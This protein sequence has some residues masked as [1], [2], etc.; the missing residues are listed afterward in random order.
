MKWHLLW[1]MSGSATL[2][3]ALWMLLAD[4]S[5]GRS[6][7]IPLL[8]LLGFAALVYFGIRA[9]SCKPGS[10][11]RTAFVVTL[12][13][14]AAIPLFSI[15]WQKSGYKQQMEAKEL[16]EQQREHAEQQRKYAEA[17]SKA[18]SDS[19]FIA[20]SEDGPGETGELERA[21]A[22]L[23]QNRLCIENFSPT[24][25]DALNR[26][27]KDPA[28]LILQTVM[29]QCSDSFTAWNLL[30]DY[31]TDDSLDVLHWLLEQGFSP[32]QTIYIV[33][34]FE[35]FSPNSRIVSRHFD[36][37]DDYSLMMSPL[38][39]LA[40]ARGDNQALN[41][42]LT[43]GA[44]ITTR[45]RSDCSALHIGARAGNIEAMRLALN[46]G[47]AP[48][49][50]ATPNSWNATPL[51]WAAMSA[52]PEAVALLLASGASVDAAASYGVTPLMQLLS[53]SDKVDKKIFAALLDMGCP[54]NISN[55]RGETPLHTLATNSF[56]HT[57]FR[58]VHTA[59]MYPAPKHKQRSPSELQKDVLEVIRLL[60]EAGANPVA[61][62]AAGNGI[63]HYAAFSSTAHSERRYAIAALLLEAGADMN[64]KDAEGRLPI[65]SRLAP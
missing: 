59:A 50:R 17:R 30:F 64:A 49:A 12:C 52:Y 26:D 19:I 1:I 3:L 8:M 37:D 34:G 20:M 53:Y 25:S 44:K 61:V 4:S 14:I 65:R 5:W 39:H 62:N 16:R 51:H 45:T 47:I 54:V 28:A 24:V 32:E 42:L 46:A 13:C 40:I 58:R 31:A 9:F 36:P 48:D 43:A 27:R 56:N 15:I 22:A 33:T 29:Q 7:A 2:I 10:P 55:V 38:T 35:H 11:A 63:L 6:E 41:M 23:P 21:L 57:L 60:R 18:L